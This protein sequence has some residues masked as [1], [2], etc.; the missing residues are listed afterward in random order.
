MNQDRQGDF[1]R[2]EESPRITF[3]TTRRHTT[4]F[5]EIDVLNTLKM[6]RIRGG[7]RHITWGAQL[8]F[9]LKIIMTRIENASF[10]YE[11]TIGIFVEKD[12]L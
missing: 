8:Q 6:L 11:L 3:D 4:P 7:W 5:Q 2:H 12:V 1:L 9:T 10:G